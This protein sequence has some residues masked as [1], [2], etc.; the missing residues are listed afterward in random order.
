MRPVLAITVQAAQNQEL[1]MAAMRRTGF[2]LPQF[3]RACERVTH[4]LPANFS[5]VCQMD[6]S[7]KM[8]ASF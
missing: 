3:G 7:M 8:F 4:L 5:F 1:F 2:C 6:S